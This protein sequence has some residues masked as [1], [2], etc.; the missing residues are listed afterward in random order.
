[1][2]ADESLKFS[3]AYKTY[4]PEESS[5]L[6]YFHIQTHRNLQLQV[7]VERSNMASLLFL[8]FLKI[9]GEFIYFCI[10]YGNV[11]NCDRV[12]CAK[13]KILLSSSLA[14]YRKKSQPLV[15]ITDVSRPGKNRTI[16][17]TDS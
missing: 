8:L 7:T 13:P 9:A 16:F 3:T 17:R 11:N 14:L 4:F 1:M 12:C 10:A 15:C 5:S 2:K 6:K